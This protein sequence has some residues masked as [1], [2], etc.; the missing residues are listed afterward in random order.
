MGMQ[1]GC[2]EDKMKDTDL[3]KD[4][5]D[6]FQ[7]A[8]DAVDADFAVAIDDL[9]F[10]YTPGSQWPQKIRAER[11]KDGRPCFEINKIPYYLDQVIGDIRQNEPSIKVK[12][13]DS[14]ADPKTAEIINGLIKNIEGQSD[15]EIAYDTAAESAVAC[16]YGAWRINTEYSQNDQ[17]EQDIVILRIKN[18]F[19]VVWGQAEKWDKSDAPHCFVTEKVPKKRFK[20]QW[21]E[22]SLTSFESSKDRN[23]LWGDD[24]S[25][26]VV[27]YFTRELTKAKLYLMKN[28]AGELFTTDMEPD[29]EKLSALG[30][31]VVKERDVETYEVK[32]CK[33]NQS[34]ILEKQVVWPGHYIPIVMVYGKEINIEGRTSY[35]GMVRYGKES[36]RLYNISRSTGV[37]LISLAPKSPYLVTKEQ[38]AGYENI[39]SNAHKK[40]YPYLPYNSD[41][42][43]QAAVPQRATPIS[44]NTGIQQEIIVA[45]QEMHDTIGLQQASLGQKSNEKSGKAI[46]ARQ[47]EGDTAQYAYYDNLG[48]AMRYS[49]KILIDLIPKIYDTARIVRIRGADN[50]DQP[51][52]INQPFTEKGNN[53]E[54]TQRIY[55]L[56]VGK[57]DVISSIG[58][59]FTTQREEA[60]QNMLAFIEAV[61]QAGPLLGDLL[62]KNLDWPGSEEIERRLKILLPPQL[63]QAS[64]PGGAAGTPPAP[65]PPPSP[66]EMIKMKGDAAK[67]QGMELDNEKKFNEMRAARDARAPAGKGA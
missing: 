28:Q 44:A 32:W 50:T 61:P 63:Q 39:W 33:A 2:Y 42:Q 60:A 47:K 64:G 3:L 66:P 13:V 16:G 59:S 6:Q 26:R 14:L 54:A 20:K 56:T 23:P 4:I 49:G 40:N 52:M 62:A 53:G 1:D 22:A 41:P 8:H 18:P 5:K 45:D 25:I 10:A 67:V 30:W 51:V 46:L 65:P 19:T 48:R 24:K 12:P 31:A 34:E 35:R 7:E 36:V 15:A 27:E 37:E 9:N 29:A 43:N 11:E 21:P 38:I 57:Y 58:P 55:D 17:F